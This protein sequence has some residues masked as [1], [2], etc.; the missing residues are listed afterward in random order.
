MNGRWHIKQLDGDDE[1]DDN[2]DDGEDIDKEYLAGSKERGI[3]KRAAMVVNILSSDFKLEPNAKIT[4]LLIRPGK[5]KG[6]RTT[7]EGRLGTQTNATST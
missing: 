6:S 3:E 7:Q 1:D 2:S 4:G 5:G